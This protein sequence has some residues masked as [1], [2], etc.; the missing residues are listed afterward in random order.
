M[1]QGEEFEI[2][3]VSYYVSRRTSRP[4]LDVYNKLL[5]TKLPLNVTISTT[6]TYG[7]RSAETLLPEGG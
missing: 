2:L 4:V 7:W 5:S 6:T 3:I 1:E